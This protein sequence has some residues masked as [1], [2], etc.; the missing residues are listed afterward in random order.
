[1]PR[2]CLLGTLVAVTASCATLPPRS[3]PIDGDR[4]HVG[5][6]THLVDPGEVQLEIGGQY[7]G[8]RRE[9]TFAS[10]MLVRIGVND[11]IEARIGSDGLVGRQGTQSARGI[12]NLQ[13]S[14]KVPI[15]GPPDAPMLSVMPAVT[16]GTASAAK[17]LGSGSTDAMVVL[18]FG[19]EL[20]HRLHLEANYGAGIIGSEQERRH[21]SQQLVTGAAVYSVTPTLAMYGEGVWWTRQQVSGSAVTVT[22]F[23]VIYT[24]RPHVLLDAGAM[25]G[26]SDAAPRYGGFAGISFLA[27]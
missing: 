21:G 13:V 6:G 2:L 9:R 12:G 14:A 7:Q 20:T 1:M 11:R 4:P 18:L 23:G 24:L 27:R 26:I 15:A 8:D 25:A 22:D 19:H 16:L 5:T 10:P 3:E 17:G